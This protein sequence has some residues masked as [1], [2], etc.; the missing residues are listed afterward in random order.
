MLGYS[1]DELRRHIEKQFVKGMTWANYGVAWHIDHVTPIA[2]FVERGVTD[3]AK[4]N[5][6]PNLQP[7]WREYNLSKGSDVHKL[8]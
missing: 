5:A 8:I 4:I 3:P 6:L 7:V 2:V 1:P